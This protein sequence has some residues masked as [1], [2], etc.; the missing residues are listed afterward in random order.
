MHLIAEEVPPELA[1]AID[2][3]V[4][5]QDQTVHIPEGQQAGLIVRPLRIWCHNVP[6]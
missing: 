5:V 6:L 2:L 3:P 1:S 4:A